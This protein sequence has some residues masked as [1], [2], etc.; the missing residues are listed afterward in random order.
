MR[1]IVAADKSTRDVVVSFLSFAIGVKTHPLARRSY[2]GREAVS[3]DGRKWLF[4]LVFVN[5]LDVLVCAGRRGNF[6]R[7]NPL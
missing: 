7:G 2:R 6:E 3:V 5:V 1:F 4:V